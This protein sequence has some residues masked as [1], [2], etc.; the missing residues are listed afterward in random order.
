MNV[1]MASEFDGCLESGP[2]ALVMIALVSQLIAILS[3]G[4]S[5]KGERMRI[6]LLHKV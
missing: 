5:V 2:T 3:C 6:L 4:A 1:V